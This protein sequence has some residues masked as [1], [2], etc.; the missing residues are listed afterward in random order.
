MQLVW[1]GRAYDGAST[2][3]TLSIEPHQSAH[4]DTTTTTT[5]YVL[6]V[7]E[8]KS[9][10]VRSMLLLFVRTVH[11]ATR[12]HNQSGP[13]NWATILVPV[14]ELGPVSVLPDGIPP[15]CL[16]TVQRSYGI[17][18]LRNAPP[19]LYYVRAMLPWR[20]ASDSDRA[21]AARLVSR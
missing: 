7:Y 20:L 5:E 2:N 3:A 13:P 6:I 18:R 10:F 8:S 19:T 11:P 12:L 21:L 9:K 14:L 4:R 16:S 1:F 15:I 17:V